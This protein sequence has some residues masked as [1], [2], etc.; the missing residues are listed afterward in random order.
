MPEE[1]V[2][3]APTKVVGGK[4]V[5]D[6]KKRFILP[7][8]RV[9]KA[10]GQEKD[11][12]IPGQFGVALNADG[13]VKVDPKSLRTSKPTVFAGGDAITG[14]ATV[15]LATRAGREAARAMD[16]YLRD[17]GRAWNAPA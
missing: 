7:C 5:E 10:I 14:A 4:V 9:I 3:F 2:E 13:T 1:G 16:A 6:A 11:R 12:S 15:I 17:P 8:D